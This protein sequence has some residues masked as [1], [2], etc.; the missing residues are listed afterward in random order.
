M[1]VNRFDQ[2]GTGEKAYGVGYQLLSKASYDPEEV[3]LEC[4][5]EIEKAL[6]LTRPMWWM[7]HILKQFA[8]KYGLRIRSRPGGRETRARTVQKLDF[9]ES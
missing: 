5:R 6:C 2:H 3:S 7:Q 8:R 4:Q 1:I 9:S